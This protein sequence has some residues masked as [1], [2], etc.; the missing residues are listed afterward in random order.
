MVWFNMFLVW[1]FVETQFLGGWGVLR[2]IQRFFL[3][4]FEKNQQKNL[5]LEWVHYIY[6]ICSYKLLKKNMITK[7]Y[8]VLLVL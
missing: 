6:N 3:E 5:L 4:N 2:P 1:N 8:I 7:I